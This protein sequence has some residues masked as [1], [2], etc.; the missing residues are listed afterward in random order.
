MTTDWKPVFASDYPSDHPPYPPGDLL[1][2]ELETRGWTQAEMARRM[3]C[4]RQT[5]TELVH[6]RRKLTP[7]LAVA[8][9][10]ALGTS[11]ELWLGLEEDYRAA[12]RGVALAS[13]PS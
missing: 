6:A 10:G 11:A 8:I 12:L 1:A 4:A 2:E 3:G 5:V 13:N 9:G 7:T